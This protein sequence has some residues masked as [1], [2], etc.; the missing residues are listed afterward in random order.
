VAVI[1]STG[2]PSNC[3]SIAGGT[4]A[5]LPHLSGKWCGAAYDR[6]PTA[7]ATFG[8]AGSSAK[9]GPIYI[10]EGY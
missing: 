3:G 9:K 4:S 8:V 1:G 7:R 6:D 5:A 2:S 10:R